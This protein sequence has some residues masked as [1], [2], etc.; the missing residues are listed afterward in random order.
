ML[1][2]RRETVSILNRY[3]E[4][5]N[6]HHLFGSCNAFNDFGRSLVNQRNYQVLLLIKKHHLNY[7]Y[8]YI[9]R[10]ADLISNK[11]AFLIIVEKQKSSFLTGHIHTIGQI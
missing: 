1:A 5:S 4:Y 8:L 7:P 2:T 9:H 3:N 6:D 11:N 10:R